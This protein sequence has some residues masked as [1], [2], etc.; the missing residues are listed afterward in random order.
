M[1]LEHL[2]TPNQP[3][4]MYGRTGDGQRNHVHFVTA[5][6]IH[7]IV[8]NKY[9]A[10]K[11]QEKS[12]SFYIF[13]EIPCIRSDYLDFRI[14]RYPISTRISTISIYIYSPPKFSRSCSTSLNSV[15][16]VE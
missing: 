14:F 12:E 1:S 10:M 8:N 6:G 16:N 3:C 4:T 7:F 11:I 13:P 5:Y 15:L 9:Y 2:D